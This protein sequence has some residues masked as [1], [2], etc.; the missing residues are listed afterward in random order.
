M[1]VYSS[2]IATSPPK[3]TNNNT[4]VVSNSSNSF[5]KSGDF[6]TFDTPD[7]LLLHILEGNVEKAREHDVN[8]TSLGRLRGHFCSDTIFSLTH[9]VLSDAEIKVLEKGLDF[10]SYSEENQ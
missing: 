10:C 8:M 4:S 1:Y 9:R 7:R 5:S 2:R 6:E 3:I